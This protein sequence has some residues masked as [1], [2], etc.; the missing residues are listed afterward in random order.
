[1]K[2]YFYKQQMLS[3]DFEKSYIYYKKAKTEH[4]ET[5]LYLV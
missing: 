4:R 3:I 2:G 5:P 1:M